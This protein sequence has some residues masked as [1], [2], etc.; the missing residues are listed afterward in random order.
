MEHGT[1]E[2][3]DEITELGFLLESYNTS[4]EEFSLCIP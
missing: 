2:D 3:E 1:D 4:R